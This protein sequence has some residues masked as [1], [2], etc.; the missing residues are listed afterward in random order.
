MAKL[1]E[2]VAAERARAEAALAKV[3]AMAAAAAAARELAEA[4][5]ERIL[6]GNGAPSAVEAGAETAAAEA[7]GAEVAVEAVTATEDG[8]TEDG[9]MHRQREEDQAAHGGEGGEDTST[10]D[11]TTAV[12]ALPPVVDTVV[13]DTVRSLVAA[14]DGEAPFPGGDRTV[15]GLYKLNAVDPTIA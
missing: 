12:D 13:V 7:A 9:D 2:E 11:A 5:F 1:E 3:A 15:E 10:A 14:V 8:A 4:G 6:V